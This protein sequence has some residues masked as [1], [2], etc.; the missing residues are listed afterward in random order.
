MRGCCFLE[1]WAKPQGGNPSPGARCTHHHS[2][3]ECQLPHFTSSFVPSKGQQ[4]LKFGRLLP[5]PPSLLVPC[6]PPNTP[7]NTPWPP[8]HPNPR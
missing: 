5:A 3:A 4:K 2:G 7:F 1:D 6:A 8:S